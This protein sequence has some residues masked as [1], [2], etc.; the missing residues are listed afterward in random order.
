VVQPDSPRIETRGTA[1]QTTDRN[2]IWRIRFTCWI[3]KATSTHSEYV[4]PI[5]FPQQQWLHERTFPVSFPASHKHA[6]GTRLTLTLTL[7]TWKK[8]LA[9]NNTSRSQ[10]GFN[11]AFKGLN[12]AVHGS[13]IY[14]L[15][16]PEI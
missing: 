11:S 14:V 7:L 10:M 5:A 3:N 8:W 16:V 13:Q 6:V 15:F 12:G 1:G 9:P 2:I 4:I